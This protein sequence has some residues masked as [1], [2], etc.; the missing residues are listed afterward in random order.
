VKPVTPASLLHRIEWVLHDD[1]PFERVGEIYRQPM[2]LKERDGL[3][4]TKAVG[5]STW[6][7]E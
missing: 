5:Q 7:L 6:T 1:R 2:L 4:R 3:K